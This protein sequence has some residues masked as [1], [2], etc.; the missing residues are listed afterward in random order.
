[1][2]RILVIGARGMLGRDLLPQ[3][4]SSFPE[5][6]VWG[7][8]VEEIDI[9][10]EKETIEKIEAL[11]P[12]VVVNVA[13]YTDVDGCEQN[14]NE[15]FAVNA[16]GMRYIALGA[17]LCGAKVVYLSTDYV[18]DGKKTTPYLE[19]DSPHPLNIYGESKLKG[20]RYV[21]ELVKGGLIIRTQWL[22]GKHGK[23]FVYAIIRQAQEK[24][25][26]SVVSDQIGSPTYTRDLSK[27]I[28]ILIQKNAQGIFHVSNEGSC[29]WFTFG[30]RILGFWGMK[31]VEVNPISSEELARPARRPSY[32]VFNTSKFER[33]VGWRLRPWSEALKEF[34]LEI[35]KASNTSRGE[36]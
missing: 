36:V 34:L 31:E 4:Q 2:S 20:E 17:K 12:R 27:A 35:R 23:N 5:E 29:S 22:F 33:E 28:A 26:L 13:A 24:K 30:Q 19:E 25:I 11:C 32:S 16:E 1:M 15:A 14:R 21:Q 3:L 6:E 7:W 10:K 8:D 18:F 9:R